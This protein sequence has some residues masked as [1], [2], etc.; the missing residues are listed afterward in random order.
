MSFLKANYV[1]H[2]DIRFNLVHNDL[3]YFIFSV[4]EFFLLYFLKTNCTK[5]KKSQPRN[6]EKLEMEKQTHKSSFHK[7]KAYNLQHAE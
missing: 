4:F 2:P 5:E 1:L 6:N 3:I 7:W